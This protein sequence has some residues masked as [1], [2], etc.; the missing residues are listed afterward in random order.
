MSAHIIEAF[1]CV[2]MLELATLHK[3]T[4]LGLLAYPSLAANF[5]PTSRLP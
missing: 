2:Q 5:L 3:Y 1:S 4:F